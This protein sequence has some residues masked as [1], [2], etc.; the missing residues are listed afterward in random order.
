MT[1]LTIRTGD[2]LREALE[3]RADL[4]G[5]TLSEVVRQ[6]L[7]DAVLERPMAERIAHLKGTL[8]LPEAPSD[9]WRRTLRERNW[10]S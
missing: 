1:T 5:V 9:E 10:R 7:S 8:S 2:E 6:I 4:L 3:Q